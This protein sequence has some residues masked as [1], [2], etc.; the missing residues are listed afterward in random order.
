M[1]YI[2]LLFLLLVS[3][4]FNGC[5]APFVFLGGIAT[6][7]IVADDRRDS[8]TMLQDEGIELNARA[9]LDDDIQLRDETHINITSFNHVVLLS[10]Q[11]PTTIL[12]Y[13][14]E[15][16]VRKIPHVKLV[17]NEIF[18]ASPSS[19]VA[20][21]SDTFIT[22]RIKN[23]IFNNNYVNTNHVK[24]VTESGVA[25][26]MGILTR[27]EADQATTAARGVHGVSKVVRLFEFLE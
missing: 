23:E 7:A 24:V 1:K 15:T 8:G 3:F 26:L 19:V 11:A 9:A 10:G 18:I 13:R 2:F 17:Y 5:A 4:I 25:F 6:G 16:L 27:T 14:A 21:A 20:R 12:R 22:A